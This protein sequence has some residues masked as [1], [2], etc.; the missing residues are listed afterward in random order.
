MKSLTNVCAAVLAA[1]VASALSLAPLAGLSGMAL[2]KTQETMTANL[3]D[4]TNGDAPTVTT[5]TDNAGSPIAWLYN[6]RRIN[7]E[8]D[9][10]S[11][12]MKQAIVSIE[13]R[14]FYEHKGVDWQG[15]IR[16]M[17]ANMFSGGVEQGAS[18]IDQQYVKNYLL[19]VDAKD[20]SEQIAATE[21]SYARKI[22]EMRMA[23][24]LEER[25]SKDEILTRYLNIVPFGSGA[26]GIESAAKTYFGIPAKDL[27][28]PQ[29]AML[30]GIVQSSSYLNPYTN[31]QAV[32]D[33]RNTVL[34]TMVSSGAITAEDSA[35]YKQ[36]PLGV[37]EEPEKLPS[38]CISAGNKGFFC[39][40][41]V[42]YLEEKGISSDDLN[43][44]GYTIK[45]TLDPNVQE[46]SHNAVVSQA[47]PQADGVAEAFNV[48]EPGKDSRHV[49]AMTSSRNYGL[50]ADNMETVLPQ[51][52]SMVGNGAGSVF[53]VFTAA[54]AMQKGM[55][56]NQVL[57][58]PKRYEARGMGSG[59]A[60][61]CP[62]ATYCVENSG[63]YKGSMTL[64]E[65]LAQ[66]PNTTFVQLIEN[67][68]VPE[69][70]DMS[71]RLG[72]RSYTQPGS[73]DGE[74][75]VADFI[76]DNN[77][78]SYT[79]GPT[80]VNPLELTNVAA[81]I[82]SD[83]MW[84]EP[85]PI[86]EIKDRHGE[87]VDIDTPDCE[88][89]LEPD[90]ARGLGIALSH[91]TKNG[92]GAAAA[93]S[94]GWST[95]VAAKTGTSESHQS[96]AFLAFNS[97]FAASS[98]VFNDGGTVSPLCTAPLRQCSWGNLYG[99]ME[100][101]RTWFAA[102]NQVPAALQGTLPPADG[103]SFRGASNSSVPDVSGLT[104]AEARARLQQ[105]GFTV[106]TVNVPGNG[107]PAG[108]VV[109]ADNGTA[110]LGRGTVTLQIS[111][112]TGFPGGG[113]ITQ[114][115]VTLD[116]ITSLLESLLNP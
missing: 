111:D 11:P 45:T 96:S 12:V 97:G 5:V 41:V 30:A 10:I 66:S 37:L 87:K 85:N 64:Q 34:D 89:V 33:R 7:V 68:G 58:V 115:P 31:K 83:G 35:K 105:A 108:H 71:V 69:T 55:G 78:G 101:A 38:G 29:S 67:V 20:E 77:L 92:T 6:Q 49:L 39:D 82:A 75:S 22:R 9:Q 76:K 59:G 14:R 113:D 81:T 47:D 86:L 116:E 42:H 114:D 103:S 43:K 65:A 25:L 53:K 88:Q 1:G 106:N 40:Y 110:M 13:D 15:T 32:I 52:T 19:L 102:A 51:T 50:D 73:Y 91:D 109:S 23:S 95:P 18:T 79:L 21:T 17:A 80:A 63:N 98:Y 28:V 72:L 4:L 62:P 8:G 54:V 107:T 60:A 24:D 26:F 44:G 48:I 27:N 74:Q 36:E 84:C 16:A 57:S 112:G 70:V 61:G 3:T 2:A 104:E 94:Y 90:I 99:G 100:A 56:I 46:A 93:N